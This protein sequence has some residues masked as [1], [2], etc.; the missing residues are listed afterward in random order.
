MALEGLAGRFWLKSNTPHIT[1]H[2]LFE[3]KTIPSIRR[4]RRRPPP[5]PHHFPATFRAPGHPSHVQT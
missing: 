1:M 2:A 4:P 5:R 3:K